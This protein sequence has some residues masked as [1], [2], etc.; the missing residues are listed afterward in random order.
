MLRYA[1]LSLVLLVCAT[2]VG[3]STTVAKTDTPELTIKEDA[4][5]GRELPSGSPLQYV[6]AKELETVLRFMKVYEREHGRDLMFRGMS[7]VGEKRFARF[8]VAYVNDAYVIA[9]FDS[10]EIRYRRYSPNSS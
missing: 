3:C 9:E 10:S 6:G 5:T 1:G 7:V 4:S 8:W 2:V